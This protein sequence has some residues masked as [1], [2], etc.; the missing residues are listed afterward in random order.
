MCRKG[1]NGLYGEGRNNEDVYMKKKKKKRNKD[2]GLSD[3]AYDNDDGL[4]VK[5]AFLRTIFMIKI[6]IIMI[7]MI[8]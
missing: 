7:I 8:L 3:E 2:G 5:I 1:D 4:M 6:A